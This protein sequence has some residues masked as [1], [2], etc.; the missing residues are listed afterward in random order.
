MRS[1][2]YSL[3]LQVNGRQI[4]AT[5]I[6]QRRRTLS[7]NVDEDALIIKLPFE[8]D[9]EKTLTWISSK[10]S[11]VQKR[12]AMIERMKLNTDEIWYLGSRTKV[13]YGDETTFRPEGI[14]VKQGVLLETVLR[15]HAIDVLGG[16]FSEAMTETRISPKTLRFRTMKRSWGRCTSKGEITLNTRL[17]ACE[18]RFIRYVCIHELMHLKHLNHSPLFW[19]EVKRHVPDVASVK[20]SSI[21]LQKDRLGL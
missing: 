14:V 6:P 13:T 8:A 20:K 5:F 2:P 12:L 9:L 16:Y 1:K 3:T 10:Q 7:M 15:Q 4:K 11:W 21:L 19:Q 17:I 18:P